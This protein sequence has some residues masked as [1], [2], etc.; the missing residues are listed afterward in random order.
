MVPELLG[1]VWYQYSWDQ[2]STRIVRTSMVPVW[3]QYSWDH[4]GTSI[5]WSGAMTGQKGT[6]LH[7]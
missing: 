6:L 1:P 2:Y 7:V 4:Y 5:R 3:Y